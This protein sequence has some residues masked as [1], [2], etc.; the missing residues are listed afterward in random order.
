MHLNNHQ[1][2]ILA[3]DD[4][5]MNIQILHEILQ[6]EYRVLFATKGTDALEIAAEH[7]PDLILLDIVMPEPDGYE[8]CRR[9]KK[10]PR[11]RH[12][13][14]IFIT[15]L[16]DHGE[17]AK[18]LEI[19][20]VDYL[21]KPVNPAVVRARVKS[22]LN[23]KKYQDFLQNLALLDGLT[24]IANRR[25]FDQTLEREWRRA[26]RASDPIALLML[27]LDFF[28]HYNDHYGHLKGDD[29]LRQVAMVLSRSTTRP[30]DLAARYG[31]E[32][33]VCLLPETNLKGALVTAEKI[34]QGIAELK[35]PHEFSTAA[36]HV[37]VSIGVASITPAF[38]ENP[39]QLITAADQAMY[40]AKKLGRNR[41]ETA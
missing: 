2:I 4:S 5:P 16:A 12:I 8:V 24:G 34:C 10:D 35:I 19:G 14:V 15:R 17:E 40:R 18:G 32:E 27:D 28:K 30:A 25:N 23:L 29:C 22:H 21:T 33:F 36:D 41:I 38:G 26:S 9:L 6:P 1:A 13:P 11:T 39:E 31:G 3:V 20:G 7:L 37:T